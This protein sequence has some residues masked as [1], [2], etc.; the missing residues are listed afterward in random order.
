VTG[1]QTCALP[2]LL[3]NSGAG[4]TS[5]IHAGLL[6]I[7]VERGFL[8]IYTRPLGLPRADIA[9]TLFST[10]F[11]GINSYRGSLV[12]LLQEAANS[13]APRRPLLI[14]D[15]FEDVL[16][17]RDQEEWQRLITDLRAL[18][19]INDPGIRVL[20]SYRADL[21]ARLG[22]SWQEI[23]GSPQ[24][25][26]RVYVSG[27]SSEDAW[28]GV[29]SACQDL[30]IKLEI[31]TQES[32][33]MGNDLF[34]FSRSHGFEGVYPPYIQMLIDHA[35]Q[36]VKAGHAAYTFADYEM[37]GGMEG[38]TGGYLKRQLSYAS[39][40]EGYL[41]K[42]LAALVRSYGVKA[43]KSLRDVSTDV[44]LA[45]EKCEQLLERLID[46]R[47]VRHIGDHYEIAHDFLAQEI[48]ASLVDSEEREFKRFREL[49]A[50]KAAA[51]NATN[52]LL[53]VGE[54]LM[55]YNHR[56]RILP[57][58]SELKLLLASWAQTEGPGLFWFLHADERRMLEL[59]AAEESKTKLEDDARAVLVLLR[60]K[61]SGQPL[62]VKDWLSFKRY[63]FGIQLAHFLFSYGEATPDSV[64]RWAIRSKNS[65]VRECLV[66]V[67]AKKVAEGDHKWISELGKSSSPFRRT[68]YEALSLRDD[69]PSIETNRASRV[70]QEFA[71]LQAVSRARNTAEARA[72][73]TA[74]K[75]FRPRWRSQLFAW[76]MATLRTVGSQPILR[77][78]SSVG[79]EKTAILLGPI[80]NALTAREFAGL[81][82][83]YTA[84]NTRESEYLKR[85][86]DPWRAASE[87]KAAA[88]SKAIGRA[89]TTKNL[90]Q[91]RRSLEHLS[92]TP[93]AEYYVLALAGIGNAKDVLSIIR[94][95]GMAPTEVLYWFQIGMASKIGKRM[96]E[97]RLPVPRFLLKICERKAFWEDPLAE[98]SRFRRR[99]LLPINNLRNQRL[100]RR[101]V[102]HAVIG[103][104][105]LN[106]ADLLKKMARHEY[107]MIARAAA[108]RLTDL[109]GEDG[110]RMLQSVIADSITE[111]RTESLALALRYAEMDV[112]SVAQLW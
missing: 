58:D 22:Q 98:R 95:V 55:L 46:L 101:L 47:L 49:L 36:T 97:L 67:V 59:I 79:A 89:A 86:T 23:S 100:Y 2:I 77:K 24:G 17:A 57:S 104:A 4:K 37:A 102:A 9:S 75:K 74:L 110:I 69:L 14:I 63:K 99:D 15:Q 25:L 34:S 81:L 70:T 56:S 45:E 66:D 68:I 12:P 33:Q 82:R 93:S 8:P 42:I 94:K 1:V 16:M 44:S 91:L 13:I 64:I 43:Q 60:Q 19:Y 52:D 41:T 76:S 3:G 112:S 71:L 87:R 78:L 105:A 84:L 103:S 62:R 28:N 107:R 18:R 90:K 109:A 32:L 40:K 65:S 21:E 61:I 20:I 48:A 83:A 80:V 53:T 111:G 96:G 11:E 106:D 10:V 35:W 72:A 88:V 108:V 26:P 51:F 6:P 38:V 31:S 92:L 54:L 27:T 85:N 30:K 73:L 50:T 29:K 5:L 39:D 7:A